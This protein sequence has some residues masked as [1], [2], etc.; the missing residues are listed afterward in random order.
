MAGWVV[1]EREERGP[2]GP[3][4]SLGDRVCCAM[5]RTIRRTAARGLSTCGIWG[6]CGIFSSFL[7]QPSNVSCGMWGRDGNWRFNSVTSTAPSNSATAKKFV[8]WKDFLHIKFLSKSQK[9]KKKKKSTPQFFVNSHH[10]HVANPRLRF[11]F[12][13]IHLCA[14]FQMLFKRE[15]W[16]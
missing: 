11:F 1:R 7:N 3:V 8:S 4:F 10:A 13:S 16:H 5:G 12:P 2:G 15:T 9:R 6:A 14:F